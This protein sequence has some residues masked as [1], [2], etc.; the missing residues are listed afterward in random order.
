MGIA[1]VSKGI[2]ASTQGITYIKQG[3]LN[4][5]IALTLQ[6]DTR[7]QKAVDIGSCKL[8]SIMKS[9]LRILHRILQNARS[10]RIL[11]NPGGIFYLGTPLCGY[12]F[13]SQPSPPGTNPR[14]QLKGGKNPP[15]RTITM[16]KNSPLDKTGSQKLHLRHKV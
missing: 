14:T 7:A 11:Q 1:T 2:L 13:H 3:C 10:Y 9:C 6:T 16:H 4:N 5:Q 15:P 8:P 12:Q